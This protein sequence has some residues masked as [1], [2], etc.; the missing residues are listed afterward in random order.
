MIDLYITKNKSY[1]QICRQINELFGVTKKN[2]SRKS[3]VRKKSV[4]NDNSIKRK[5]IYFTKYQIKNIFTSPVY[6]GHLVYFAGT[7]KE[8]IIYNHHEAI[9]T[10]NIA[11]Q[12]DTK[13]K[14]NRK[15]GGYT[16]QIKYPLSLFVTCSHCGHKM[17]VA[18]KGSTTSLTYVSYYCRYHKQGLCD[19][20]KR[21]RYLEL[22][23]ALIKA[24]CSK[25][26]QITALAVSGANQTES[27]QENPELLAK[28]K[29]LEDYKAMYT[30]HQNPVIKQA[31]KALQAEIQGFNVKQD[32]KSINQETLT[33]WLL[34]NPYLA[35]PNYYRQLTEAEK[36]SLYPRFVD[37]ILLSQKEYSVNLLF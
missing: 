8:E 30:R 27:V 16:N 10:P 24:I 5:Q 34:A 4:E 1:A 2:N 14:T 35:D 12:L 29:E 36:L 18:R 9:I 32:L 21:Y 3:S 20:G 17:S 26:K 22:E 19:N 37:K 31:I 33:N 7:P 13:L 15:L 6:R 11:E 25:H 28:K 23:E